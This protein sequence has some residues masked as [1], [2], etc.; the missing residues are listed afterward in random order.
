MTGLAETQPTEILPLPMARR[1]V[2]FDHTVEG[3]F[4]VAL[5]G[6][7]S[8]ATQA[9]LRQAGLDLSK[10]LQPA[11]PFDVWKLCLEIVARDL[12]PRLPCAEAWRKLGRAIVE[13][14]SQRVMGRVMVRVS[15][16]LGP[17][18]ALRRLDH[19]LNS[20]ANYVE[21]RV[22]ERSPTCIEVWIND[23]MGQPSYYQGIL[24]ASLVMTG[25]EVG[26]VELISRES[27]GATY[28]VSWEE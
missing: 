17:L 25:T 14:M 24:E 8:P 1:W 16:L 10:K 20:A 4:L 7:L 12:Y 19:I 3:L 13:G 15:R 11:Y 28:R 6:R 2:V 23:V 9:S 22:T 21:A 26:Q 5:R 27:S 18:R